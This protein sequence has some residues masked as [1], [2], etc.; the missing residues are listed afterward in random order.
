MNEFQRSIF[1]LRHALWAECLLLSFLL[2]A[3]VSPAVANNIYISQNGSGS[4][5][6]ADG[7]NCQTITWW[8]N[9]TNWGSG[10][11]QI[12]PGTIGN[13]VGTIT[14]TIVFCGGGTSG[15]PIT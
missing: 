12:G 14:N 5:S 8:N 10:A 6:G 4:M 13:L 11:N 15:N 1:R 3:L 2:G 7:N 9:A